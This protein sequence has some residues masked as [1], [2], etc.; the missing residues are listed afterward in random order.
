M[1]ECKMTIINR[2]RA[3]G[4]Y[5]A[6]NNEMKR[7]ATFLCVIVLLAGGSS[8]WAW[9]P[10]GHMA[11]ASMAYDELPAARRAELAELLKDHPRYEVDFR[12]AIPADVPVE[13]RDRWIFMRAAIWPD[14]ARSFTG[15][16]LAA[17]HR[18][19]WH[20][21]DIPVF[22]DDPAR[23]AIHPHFDLDYHKATAE[24]LMN[25]VQALH[26]NLDDLNDP[27]VHRGKKAVALCWVLHL[28]GDLHQ[29][30]HGAA[31][32][33]TGRFRQLPAGD[34]GGNEIHVHEKEGLLA[35]FKT[36]N[37]HAL[38]DCALGIDESYPAL[39][40]V[41]EAI[42]A[43]RGGVASSVAKLDP[44]DW[45]Q[46]SNAV[47]QEVVYTR[48]VLA[49]VRAG[50]ANPKEPLAVFEITDEYMKA[51]REAARKRAAMAGLRTAAILR[52][53]R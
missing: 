6:A 8:A 48:E 44:A 13:Q 17:Y 39:M 30:L 5:R 20:Y 1:I 41:A 35:S 33:S 45:A 9:N 37:L 52:G 19:I 28:A 11:I 50:E 36:P 2:C 53:E 14:V 51:A 16:D 49:L 38:W 24:Q 32:F 47:A 26:K 46:E 25:A 3:S 31:L 21:L 18:P 7:F 27:M 42:K 34:R 23:D 4:V 43:E 10:V 29:P 40:N 22:L 15:A 12:G